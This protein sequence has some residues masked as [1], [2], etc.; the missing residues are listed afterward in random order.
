MSILFTITSGIGIIVLYFEN[1]NIDKCNEGEEYID[2][3]LKRVREGASLIF[4]S[5]ERSSG[6]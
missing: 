3:N 1:N 4:D 5:I 2:I 6:A